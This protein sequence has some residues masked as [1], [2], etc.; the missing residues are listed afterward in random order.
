MEQDK[1]R[2]K[3]A[4]RAGDIAR[5]EEREAAKAEKQRL[6]EEKRVAAEQRRLAESRS[7]ASGIGDGERRRRPPAPRR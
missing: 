6:R 7:A 2:R 4:D 3:A 5:R 1:A